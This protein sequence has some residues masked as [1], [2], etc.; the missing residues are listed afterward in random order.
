MKDRTNRQAGR[1][2][3]EL[4]E[5]AVHLLRL[6][7]A[8]VLLTYYAGALPFVLTLLYYWADMSRGS[9]A[10]DRAGLGALVLAAL[11]LW[12]KTWQ[13]VFAAQLR[14]R[15]SG[16]A[17]APWTPRRLGRLFAVQ[18]AL[19]P[20]GL[21]VLP[22]SVPLIVT[23]GW[24][25]A[26]SQNL[27]AVAAECDGVRAS[28]RRAAQQAGLWKGQ[29][30]SLLLILGAFG[31]FVFIDSAVGIYQVPSIAKT[32]L[33]IETT[34]TRS[35]LAAVFNT[36][37]LATAVAVAWLCLDPLVKA[38]YAL[39]CFYGE[40]LQTGEDLKAELKPFVAARH[41]AAGAALL[42]MM[43][44]GGPTA[45]AAETSP[46]KGPPQARAPQSAIPAPE[47]ERAIEQTLSR[48]EYDW[49]LPREKDRPADTRPMTWWEKQMDDLSKTIVRWRTAAWKTI[50][51]FFDWLDKKMSRK[52]RSDR[53]S[54]GSFTGWLTSLQALLFLLLALVASAVAILFWRVWKQ[55]GRRT[56]VL[57]EAVAA[58]PDLTDENI[59]ASQ[60]PEDGWLRLAQEM[61]AAGNL[62]LALR[63]LYLA[64]LA[65]LAQ[66]ELISIA[67]FKSNLEYARELRRRA[68]SLP[69]VQAAF[70][71]NVGIFDRVWY[72]M[73]EVTQERL[74]NFE[75]NFDRI[76]AA[77]LPA[78]Q[79]QRTV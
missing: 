7:P 50:R 35:G 16:H 20:L 79:V 30:A 33:G 66:R 21:F 63:A 37:Y 17:A 72:G 57:A 59:A 71:E 68:R 4:I 19:Q 46:D 75:G 36:T 8:G 25:F 64:S 6:A 14:A 11:F 55:R 26:F 62:R 49:R 38:A 67:K 65:H 3:L 53:R 48:A 29:N 69:D 5:E 32:L 23:F 70:T 78:P 74:K 12:M 51:E 13:A 42:L 1:G 15:I 24:A 58:K 40:S 77:A 54:D 41:L 22:L 60:L 44:A 2:A 31:L 45:L 56:A 52:P 18:A 28:S 47:L 27:T 61:M 73:H 43:S 10:S 34:F 9:Y 76:R 39:R